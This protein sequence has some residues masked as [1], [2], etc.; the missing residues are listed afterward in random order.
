MPR[1]K[2]ADA[3]ITTLYSGG[4]YYGTESYW[5]YQASDQRR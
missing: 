3:H 2:C 4:A 5:H 1:K